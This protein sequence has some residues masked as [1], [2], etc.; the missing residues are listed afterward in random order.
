V[1]LS[2]NSKFLMPRTTQ[3]WGCPYERPLSQKIKNKNNGTSIFMYFSFILWQKI[4]WNVTLIKTN[5]WLLHCHCIMGGASW[6]CR[7]FSPECFESS[8]DCNDYH[9]ANWTIAHVNAR[10]HKLLY[11][12]E[13]WVCILN[14]AFKNR[15]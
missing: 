9:W 5:I 13:L 4:I 11:F 8:R 3:I 2:K 12:I 6:F 10:N 1:G 7:G 14:T 15:A